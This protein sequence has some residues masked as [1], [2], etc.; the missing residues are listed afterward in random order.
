MMRLGNSQRK[1]LQMIPCRV[2]LTWTAVLG[3]ASVPAGTD[4]ATKEADGRLH[5]A[6]MRFD[7]GKGVRIDAATFTDALSA[8]LAKQGNFVC[9]ERRRIS[10]VIDEKDFQIAMR[11]PKRAVGLAKLLKADALIYGSVGRLGAE[12]V[13]VCHMVDV[14]TGKV[15][16]SSGARCKGGGSLTALAAQTAGEVLAAFPPEGCILKLQKDASG[17]VSALIDLGKAN[18]VTAKTRLIA[19]DEQVITHPR[20]KKT[21]R[22]VRKLGVLAPAAIEQDVTTAD[23]PE[24][25]ATKLK[26]GQRVQ[27]LTAVQ[28]L[29]RAAML[30]ETFNV[31]IE[32]RY[33]FR[34]ALVRRGPVIWKHDVEV[35]SS[36]LATALDRSSFRV[37]FEPDPKR[38]SAGVLKDANP[39]RTS[40]PPA[41]LILRLESRGSFRTSST[42]TGL[43]TA[44][45]IA[46]QTQ[47]VL[48]DYTRT[49][50]RERF[51]AAD[52]TRDEI[53]K[54]VEAMLR[55]WY[56]KYQKGKSKG[57]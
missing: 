17:G 19:L 1:R 45:V 57:E 44:K 12:Y 51:D 10:R 25:V 28:Q 43:F 2:L 3:A 24:A 50:T 22:I 46:A 49:F 41:D 42:R 26:P 15:L 33:L 37:F 16:V 23:V 55:Q 5:V 13:A 34:T 52:E 38:D 11:D 31:E 48:A 36:R 21:L 8:T 53:V 20:T 54:A 29:K 39:P 56:A 18:G 7:V 27:A 4:D 40:G 14:R 47:E 35:V 32:K 30:G 9:I 6:I